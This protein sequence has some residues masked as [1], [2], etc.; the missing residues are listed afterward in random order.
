MGWY[1]NAFRLMR[2]CYEELDRDPA[3]CRI[4]TWRDAFK[5]DSFTGAMEQTL[6]GEWRCWRAALPMAPGLP[7][8]RNP[9]R[10]TGPSGTTWS[11]PRRSCERFSTTITTGLDT[12]DQ[13]AP[14]ADARSRPDQASIDSI[15]AFIRLGQLGTLAGLIQARRVAGARWLGRSR[16]KPAACFYRS[17]KRSLQT[18]AFSSCDRL[19]ER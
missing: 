15:A 19:R 4:A 3:L 7:E 14:V 12:S 5:P 9:I 2:Q 10:R 13:S 16:P 1:Q 8:I 18:P 11:A 6:N 17:S